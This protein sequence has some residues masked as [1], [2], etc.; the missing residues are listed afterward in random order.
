[1]RR[2]RVTPPWKFGLATL[3]IAVVLTYLGAVQDIP[4]VNEPYTV[5]AA[6][7]D[8]SGIKPGSPV[9]IAG[10]NVGE[11]RKV[12]AAPGAKD[13]AIV[14]MSVK[15]DGR[16]L[17][18]DASARIRPRIF[19]EGNFFVDLRPGSSSA[20]E[21][22]ED[23]T[24]PATRTANPVQLSEVVSA[25]RSDVRRNLQTT[26]S[27]IGRAQEDGGADELRRSLPDQEVA[28]RYSAIVADE[29]LG[30][31][32][33]DLGD[34]IRDQG[35]VSEALDADRAALQGLL[36]NFN[37]TFGALADNEAD[38]RAAVS[39]LPAT[40]RTALPAFASLNAAFPSVRRFAG[41]TL[42][43]VRSTRPAVRELLPF[44]SQVRGL[45]GRGE[46]RGLS[47]D[48]R[49]ATPGLARTAATAVPLLEQLRLFSS[50][51][52]TTFLPG[53]EQRVPDP[54]FAPTGPMYAELA[55]S[56][57]GLGGESRSSDANGPW[58]KVL[59]QG[60]LETVALGSGLVGVTS[61]PFLGVNP[62]P[63]RESPP[64][65]PDVPCETQEV[66]NFD[67]VPVAAPT[68]TR[69][70]TP[71]VRARFDK[72]RKAATAVLNEQ[73][74]REGSKLR[75][76]DRVASESEVDAF[77][78]KLGLT[79]QLERLQAKTRAGLQR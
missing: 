2:R 41:A 37:R 50:C 23:A 43:A 27:E 42:P 45:V 12:E 60:G 66:A 20:G 77:V 78:D 56:F 71:A 59:G 68:S 40:L 62:P 67:T 61:A 47:G 18:A 36:T 51:L 74:K 38:M 21:L 79:D 14:T 76:A 55:K 28:Y 13:A 46:L 35:T 75:V 73:F 30:L 49:S 32:R 34:L 1:V 72:A 3:A 57:V 65:Q 63:K 33:G 17:H 5:K 31:Q 19:L 39:E 44:I 64:L 4:F 22:G 52:N 9:R 26:F 16:P 24:I 10:V 11:V 69:R 15:D 8:S 58:F 54:N 25:L 29:L 7:R 6:F 70:D 48:L 53:I